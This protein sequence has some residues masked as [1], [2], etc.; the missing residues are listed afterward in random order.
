[1]SG[2]FKCT[3]APSLGNG[4]VVTA[5]AGA[6]VNVGVG[7]TIALAEADAA[8]DALVGIWLGSTVTA[9]TSLSICAETVGL[10]PTSGLLMYW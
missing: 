1:M 10:P 4:C 3:I 7:S 2:G 9:V 8:G 6:K 5:G